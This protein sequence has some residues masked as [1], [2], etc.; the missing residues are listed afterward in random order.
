MCVY[1]LLEALNRR[2]T[3]GILIRRMLR[4]LVL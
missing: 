3:T 4:I 1:I 2:K